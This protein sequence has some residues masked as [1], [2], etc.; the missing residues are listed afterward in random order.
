MF[1]GLILR[2]VFLFGGGLYIAGLCFVL[3]FVVVVWFMLCLGFDCDEFACLACRFW[4]VLFVVVAVLFML[5]LILG[6]V[7]WG[8]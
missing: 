8:G 6:L 4:C 7:V 2:L 1:A 3:L 5:C